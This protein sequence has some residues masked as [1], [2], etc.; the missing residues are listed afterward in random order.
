M[1]PVHGSTYVRSVFGP[2]VAIR[3]SPIARRGRQRRA[4]GCESLEMDPSAPARSSSPPCRTRNADGGD[5]LNTAVLNGPG[6][7]FPGITLASGNTF[8]A[9]RLVQRESRSAL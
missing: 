7:A 3:H 9:N 6:A 2:L 5:G 1:G 4:V 8:D